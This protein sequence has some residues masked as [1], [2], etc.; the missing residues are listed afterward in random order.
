MVD[1]VIQYHDLNNEKSQFNYV[2]IAAQYNDQWIWVRQKNKDTWEIPGGHVEDSETPEMAARRELWEETGALDFDLT[3][4]CDFSI[5]QI[6]RR[7]YNRLFFCR[8]TK[9]GEIPNSEIEEIIF[10]NKSPEQLTHGS[11]QLKLLDKVVELR[12]SERF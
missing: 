4:V 11:I 7:S 9:I 5:E 3:P 10:N 1:F 2:V 8:I 6:D 12:A